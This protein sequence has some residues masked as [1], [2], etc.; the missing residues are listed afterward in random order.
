MDKK[1]SDSEIMSQLLDALRYKAPEFADKLGYKSSAS[2]Y[3][4]IKEF[5]GAKIT[6]KMAN[7]I[8][9]LFPNVNMLFLVKGELPILVDNSKAKA[10]QNILGFGKNSQA[11]FDDVPG[12]LKEM[13]EVLKEIRDNQK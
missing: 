3:N 11:G 7:K 10:Q 6:K 8:V 12:I 4:V 2:I 5:G 13:L 9:E 1:L